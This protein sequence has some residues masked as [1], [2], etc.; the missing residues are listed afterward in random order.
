M[1][2]SCGPTEALMPRIILNPTCIRFIWFVVVNIVFII[3]II[4]LLLFMFILQLGLLQKELPED[5]Y[6]ISLLHREFLWY[7]PPPP[8]PPVLYRLNPQPLFLPGWDT[9][10]VQKGYQTQVRIFVIKPKG[11]PK[12]PFSS[13]NHHLV[14]T[15]GTVAQ[16]Q[17][18]Y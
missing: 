11:S 9:D 1:V 13:K 18:Y 6:V 10:T 3:I 4:I 16:R 7:P 12:A 5:E 17:N 15:D 2:I 8:P 14:V